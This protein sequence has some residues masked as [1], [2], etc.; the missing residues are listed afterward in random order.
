M[1]LYYKYSSTS[2]EWQYP[3]DRAYGLPALKIAVL[4]SSRFVL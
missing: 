2:T 4:V 1:E 3:R